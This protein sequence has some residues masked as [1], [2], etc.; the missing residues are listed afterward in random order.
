MQLPD[1]KQNSILRIVQT[2]NNN[3]AD[4]VNLVAGLAIGLF[5][6]LLILLILEI[7]NIIVILSLCLC[8]YYE[9]EDIIWVTCVAICIPFCGFIVVL[10]VKK[11]CPRN[12]SQYLYFN[13]L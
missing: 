4:A 3:N 5:V 10:S 1:A 7:V 2:T 11:C 8:N 12:Y 9:P 6:F 13:L